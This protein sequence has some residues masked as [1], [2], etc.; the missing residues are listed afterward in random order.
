MLDGTVAVSDMGLSKLE[1]RDTTILTQ[2]FAIMGT[3]AF[4]APEQVGSFRDADAKTDICQ[5]GKTLYY[6]MTGQLPGIMDFSLLP[7][8]LG[9]IVQKATR[10][11]PTDRYGTVAELLDAINLF[12]SAQ[13]PAATLKQR[14]EVYIQSAQSL[15]QQNRYESATIASIIACLSEALAADAD[16]FLDYFDKVP[17]PLLGVFENT[18]L[19]DTIGVL[20]GYCRTLEKQVNNHTWSYA[21]DVARRM[22]VI[23]K[24]SNDGHIRAL[25]LQ[26]VL[27]AAVERWRFSAMD[28]FIT[29][30]KQVKASEA[31]EVADI[32]QRQKIRYKL[33]ADKIPR[34]E[35][36]VPLQAAHDAASA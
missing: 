10:T 25:A 34:H 8:G 1:S 5:L 31:V 27:I 4:A 14:Y 36:V 12:K 18:S 26:A 23:F 29:M 6:L 32:I 21:E 3:M 19:Q 30:L 15:L 24:G 9:Y 16:N 22:D 35:L 33:M 17:V 20:E 28:S 2:T 13:S 11:N 7:P